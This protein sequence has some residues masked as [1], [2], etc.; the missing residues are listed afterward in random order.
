MVVQMMTQWTGAS[1]QDTGAPTTC[2]R[3]VLAA[4]SQAASAGKDGHPDTGLREG[5]SRCWRRYGCAGSAAIAQLPGSG[6]RTN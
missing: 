2:G 1:A 4:R 5:V 3:G 6:D